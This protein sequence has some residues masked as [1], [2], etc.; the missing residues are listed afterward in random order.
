MPS[1]TENQLFRGQIKRIYD[2][3]RHAYGLGFVLMMSSLK[4]ERRFWSRGRKEAILSVCMK[5]AI[6][7]NIFNIVRCIRHL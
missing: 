1:T 4:V 7:L 2:M 3:L 6:D 5:G